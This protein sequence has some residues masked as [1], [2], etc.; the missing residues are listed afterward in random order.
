[1]VFECTFEALLITAE[2]IPDEYES[3]SSAEG[4][5]YSASGDGYYVVSGYRGDE[6]IYYTRVDYNETFYSSLDFEYP[7]NNAEA[8]ERVLLEF[9]EN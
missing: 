3:K 1:M 4:V 5:T 6:T 9:L 7:T 8:C 2:D